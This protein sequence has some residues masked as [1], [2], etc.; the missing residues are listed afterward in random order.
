MGQLNQKMEQSKLEKALQAKEIEKLQSD[1]D[2]EKERKAREKQDDLDS[3][4]RQ[5]KEN[6][7]RENYLTK[8]LNAVTERADTVAHR[9]H[10]L[11]REVSESQAE[12]ARLRKDCQSLVQVISHLKSQFFNKKL[13]MP[14]FDGEV[15]G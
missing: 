2:R 15:S 14:W 5:L 4:E 7:E 10:D 13:Q 3:L 12:A 1:L 11:Q 6:S 9:N 8:H